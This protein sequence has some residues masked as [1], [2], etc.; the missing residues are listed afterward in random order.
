MKR[1]IAGLL[2][3]GL[4][5]SD[6]LFSCVSAPEWYRDINEVYPQER[7]IAYRGQGD[8][9][10]QAENAALGGIA[11]YFESEIITIQKTSAGW[12]NEEEDRLTEV[13]T[14]VASQIGLIAVRYAEDTWKTLPQ[15][16][17]T[18]VAY[19]DREEAWTMYRPV[20][21]NAIATLLMLFQKAEDEADPFTRALRFD[22]AGQYA[23]GTEFT[24]LRGFVQTL[25]PARAA[26]H[27]SDADAV[28]AVLPERIAAARLKA[29]V[30]LDCPLDLDGLIHDAA[31]AVFEAGGFPVANER[32]D[33]AAVCVIQVSEGV[34]MRQPVGTFY[35]PELSGVITG[36]AGAVIMFTARAKNPALIR[37]RAY[38]ALAQVVRDVLPR[39]LENWGT[40]EE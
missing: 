7:F 18:I 36:R 8:T 27:F 40:N 38:I 15:A 2:A 6:V 30:Y 22:G 12:L 32:E 23:A 13:S 20:V 5:I 19:I 39:H 35:Y 9:R 17:Y 28:C 14:I 3:A 26:A 4:F 25:F 33:A 21:E 24:T 10:I 1:N 29:S 31:A 16:K 11:G 34:Q 37:R